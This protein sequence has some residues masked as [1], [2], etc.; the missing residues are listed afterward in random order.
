MDFP[1]RNQSSF[2]SD[3]V[4]KFEET[5]FDYIRK[6]RM[7]HQKQ[8]GQFVQYQEHVDDDEGPEDRDDEFWEDDEDVPQWIRD[9]YPDLVHGP[10]QSRK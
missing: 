3:R 1:D 8:N 9:K 10:K 4:Q 7:F 6:N 2:L 5:A